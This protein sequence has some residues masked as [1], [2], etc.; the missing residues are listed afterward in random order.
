MAVI[1]ASSA[2]RP[3]LV[4]HSMGGRVCLTAAAAHPEAISGLVVLDASVRPPHRHRDHPTVSRRVNRFYRTREEI[5]SRFRLLPEQPPASAEIMADL[6]D[7]AIVETPRGW[8]WKYDPE[9]LM[10]FTDAAVD[11]S[12]HALRSPFGYVYGSESVVVD[13]ALAAYVADVVPS[14]R[15]ERVDG[16]H[17]H[18]I[19]DQPQVCGRLIDEMASSFQLATEPG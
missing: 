1:E 9:S 13:E 15:V 18:L 3:V 2:R 10:R 19:L 14:A 17:H 4:G 7:H 6:A 11:A 5:V 16:A 12:T 8:T